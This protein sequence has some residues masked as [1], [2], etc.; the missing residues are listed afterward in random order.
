MSH[1]IFAV[2]VL[3]LMLAGGPSPKQD[4]PKPAMPVDA[5]GVALPS[6]LDRVLR[7]YERAWRAGDAAALASL[8]AQD[9][10]VLPSNSPPIRGRAAIRANYEKQAGAALRL[11]ALSFATKGTIGYIIGASGY[12]NKPGDTGKFTL[13]LRR[14]PGERWLIFSDMDNSST[15]PKL[16]STPGT[17]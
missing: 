5:P 13:T 16:V 2:F 11:R 9:G 15:P 7:E 3:G 6:E 1:S 12:D 14:A 17:P 8:F 4:V 10:F